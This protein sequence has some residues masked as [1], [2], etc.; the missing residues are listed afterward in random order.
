MPKFKKNTSPAMMTQIPHIEANSPF[1][2][3]E[4]E[5]WPKMTRGVSGTLMPTNF[6]MLVGIPQ[7]M[8]KDPPKYKD[9]PKV[10]KPATKKVITKVASKLGGLFPWKVGQRIFQEG[11]KK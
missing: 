5:S 9:T 11:Q 7:L 2:Q 8:P 1:R 3:D 4:E 6:P 10:Q